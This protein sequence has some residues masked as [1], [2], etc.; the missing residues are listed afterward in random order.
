MELDATGTLQGLDATVTAEGCEL[1]PRF[2]LKLVD[3][4]LCLE[5]WVGKSVRL[6]WLGY[7]CLEC[8]TDIP[9]TFS[10]GYCYE[11][12]ATLARCDVCFVSPNRCH[13]AA[14]TCREPQWAA[15]VCMQP[16]SVYLAVTS[17]PKV[18]ITRQG[19]EHRRW[20][21][22]GATSALKIIDAPSRRAAGCIE[23]A[24]ARVLSDRTDWKKLIVGQRKDYDLG[25][26]ARQL[27]DRHPDLDV[28]LP[29][30]DLTR[31]GARW[32]QNQTVT[33]IH[34]PR[35]ANSPAIRLKLDESA[36]VLYER[37]HGVLG[38]YLLFESGV[39]NVREHCGILLRVEVQEE[40]AQPQPADKT[41]NA[42][43]Q[44][45]F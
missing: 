25:T 13:D 45:L 42:P 3:Q 22:Q 34:Q 33:V 24:F 26:L 16:H 5:E 44:S 18:G 43:Q 19:R 7:Q 21:D 1:Y 17:G 9:R 37:F 41:S 28:L 2:A 39:L 35:N 12:F 11:C 40:L 10:G 27:R 4:S 32:V 30:E 23:F 29:K 36:P 31:G 14:G 20:V 6:S 38:G 8:G 15:D